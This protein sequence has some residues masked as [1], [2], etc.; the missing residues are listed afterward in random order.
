MRDFVLRPRKAFWE[1]TPQWPHPT[2][3]PFRRRWSV[4]L[5]CGHLVTGYPVD[6]VTEEMTPCSECG[7]VLSASCYVCGRQATEECRADLP[8][9]F[10]YHEGV[11]GKFV[12][13]EHKGHPHRPTPTKRGTTDG[14]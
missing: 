5:V 7:R 12:C 10:H 6:P 2:P 8:I 4:D 14:E 3:S 1:T 11:C 13:D 9:G